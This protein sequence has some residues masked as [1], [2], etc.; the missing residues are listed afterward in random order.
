[1]QNSSAFYF[2]P[3]GSDPQQPKPTR[4]HDWIQGEGC[5][6]TGATLRSQ[7]PCWRLL[8]TGLLV[9]GP[10]P[11]ISLQAF[12]PLKSLQGLQRAASSPPQGQISGNSSTT[13]PCRPLPAEGADRC[14]FW[15]SVGLSVGLTLYLLTNKCGPILG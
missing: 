4:G 12:S 11:R 3:L 13:H 5:P 1:M 2:W 8:L 7:A 6:T 15:T 10:E 9:N 14:I